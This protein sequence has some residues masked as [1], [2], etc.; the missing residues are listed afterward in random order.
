[1]ARAYHVDGPVLIKVGT[2]A[3]AALEELGVSEDGVDISLNLYS[4]PVM[5]DAAGPRVPVDLQ[6]MGED[7]SIT[8]RLTDF[9]LVIL[10]KIKALAIGNATEGVGG[11][12]GSLIGTGGSAYRVVLT[13]ADEPWRF[14]TC[15]LRNPQRHKMGTK[16]KTPA[17]EFY[18]WRYIAAGGNTSAGGVLYDHTA[19]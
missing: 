4:E 5:S 11:A 19:T 2:G 17:V 10:N 13:S 6:R 15:T 16:Y 9:D 8:F 18:A 3:A 12:P 7:A 14:T 1:M